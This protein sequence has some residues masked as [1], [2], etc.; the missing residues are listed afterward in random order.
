MLCLGCPWFG[1]QGSDDIVYTQQAQNIC[2]TFTQRRPNVCDVGPTLCK[3][4][5][6]VL[7]LLSKAQKTTRYINPMLAQ[8]WNISLTL[9]QHWTTVYK[10]SAYP[11]NTKRWPNVGLTL[12]HRLRRWPNISPTLG[13]GLVFAG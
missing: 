9:T 6:N 11:A 12:A 2:I 4:Y 8:W 3:C 13:Q 1:M 5:T 10:V 7:C